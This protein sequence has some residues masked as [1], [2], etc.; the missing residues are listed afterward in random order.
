MTDKKEK[1]EEKPQ[2]PVKDTLAQKEQKRNENLNQLIEKE[3]PKED[4]K[5]DNIVKFLKMATT[6]WTI[7]E[8]VRWLKHR[9]EAKLKSKEEAEAA[10]DC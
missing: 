5:K 4:R 2:E 3:I 6:L 7:P 9:K 1:Q 10:K 8:K